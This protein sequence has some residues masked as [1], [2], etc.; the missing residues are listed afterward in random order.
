MQPPPPWRPLLQGNNATRAHNLVE[1]LVPSL[2]GPV[3][4]YPLLSA[5][6]ALFFGYRSLESGASEDRARCEALLLHAQSHPPDV[7]GLY[8]GLAGLGWI[9]AHLQSLGLGTPRS[10]PLQRSIDRA[11]MKLL[12]EP[13]EGFDL[14]DGLAGIGLYAAERR[15]K[16]LLASVLKQLDALAVREDRGLHWFTGADQALPGRPEEGYID[17]GVAHGQ[18]GVLPVLGNALLLGVEEELARR[19]LEGSLSFLDSTRDAC[20]FTPS[21]VTK[22]GEIKRA[23]LA[24]CYGEPGWTAVEQALALA[25]PLPGSTPRP[26]E[27]F[28][29]SKIVD[30]GLCHGAAGMAHLRA[31]GSRHEGSSAEE[32]CD[33]YRLL[34]DRLPPAEA[35]A[36]AGTTPGFLEGSSGV[37]LALTA[38]LNDQDP[39]W[40]ALLGCTLIAEA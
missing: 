24:W 3:E 4:E 34:L 13:F 17:L 21:L 25:M 39:R 30:H 23:R 5:H 31:R 33:W 14:I 35:A 20:V 18:P 8:A 12:E 1:A 10:A 37:A 22:K 15:N 2:Q 9:T 26:R 27:P 7:A 38:A 36:F 19:L 16:D 29:P 28:Q 40:D 6:A 11:L 32:A